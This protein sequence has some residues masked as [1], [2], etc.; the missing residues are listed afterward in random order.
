MK[1]SNGKF[2]L[3]LEVRT[4]LYENHFSGLF[5]FSYVFHFHIHQY[6]DIFDRLVRVHNQFHKHNRSFRY[7]LHKYAD[8]GESRRDTRLHFDS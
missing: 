1:V 6:L 5:N 2:I 8:T 4:E 3:C 7:C